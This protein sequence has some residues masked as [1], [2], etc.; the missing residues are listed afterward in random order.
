MI[1]FTA[2]PHFN[3]SNIIK[4]CGRPFADVGKMNSVLMQKL[5]HI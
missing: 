2:D 5:Y 3:H 1:Y 4:L